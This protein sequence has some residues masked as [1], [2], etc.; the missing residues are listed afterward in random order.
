MDRFREWAY[1]WLEDVAARPSRP[2]HGWQPVAVDP[3]DVDRLVE[4]W[5]GILKGTTTHLQLL[6]FMR[7][8]VQ[9]YQTRGAP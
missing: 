8:L 3:S 2:Q 1:L 6:D 7:A 9:Q 4:Y 5:E